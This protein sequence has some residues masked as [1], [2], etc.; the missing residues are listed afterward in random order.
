MGRSLKDDSGVAMVT[1]VGIILVMT[2]IAIAAFTL[3]MQSLADTTRVT[4]NTQAFQDANSGVDVALARMQE[5]GWSASAPSLTGTTS[6]GGTYQA[7][8]VATSNDEYVCTSVGHDKTG[9][10]S[11]IIVKFFYLSIWNMEMANGSTQ[12]MGGG[13]WHGNAGVQGP[14]YVWGNMSL[15]GNSSITVGP[16]FVRDGAVTVG[17]SGSLGTAANPI[18]V[19]ASAGVQGSTKQV[20]ASVSEE[21]PV[22]NLPVLDLATLLSDYQTAQRQSID[23]VEGDST[24]TNSE[25]T[26]A[27]QTSYTTMLPPNSATWTRSRAGG[28]SAYYKVVGNA[29]GPSIL[30]NNGATVFTI[31]GTSFG[32]WYGDG[33]TTVAG[34][35]DDFA[36][37]SVNHILYVEGTVFIDGPL[38]FATDVN[39]VGNGTLVVNGNVT[40][41][42][43]FTPVAGNNPNASAQ[44]YCVGIVTPG[45]ITFT[46]GDYTGAFFTSRIAELTTTNIIVTGS[47]I[48]GGLSFDKPNDVLIASPLL[49]SY[50]PRSMPGNGISVLTKGAWIREY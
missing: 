40:F 19:Y 33:H 35:H 7:S 43:Q 49:P 37:D 1:V 21:V 8:V 39:Y 27:G 15:S 24:T 4:N 5:S 10:E 23:N 41:D 16:L 45:N 50:L 11:T 47:I 42:G 36:Y 46:K 32:T 3:T 12:A 31:G 44:P 6:D 26:S 13:T 17:G 48:A 25:C 34:Q 9:S 20:Y 18:N 38:T 29:T 28:A 30:D 22:I 2:V 14:L